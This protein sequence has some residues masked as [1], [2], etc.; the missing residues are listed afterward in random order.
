MESGTISQKDA[1]K[2][3]LGI[4]ENEFRKQIKWTDTKGPLSIG[5][6]RIIRSMMKREKLKEGYSIFKEDDFES[7]ML[8]DVKTKAKSV[9]SRESRFYILFHNPYKDDQT[10]VRGLMENPNFN[11]AAF[12]FASTMFGPLEGGKFPYAARLETMHKRA[13]QGEFASIST[14]GATLWR[15]YVLPYKMKQKLGPDERKINRSMYTLEH[16]T[17]RNPSDN[18]L[19]Y[20]TILKDRT[21]SFVVNWKDVI[22]FRK[23]Y[24]DVD[25]VKV[26]IHKNVKVHFGYGSGEGLEKGQRDDKSQITDLRGKNQRVTCIFSSTIDFKKYSEKNTIKAEPLQEILQ[27]AAYEG[28]IF[29]A[30]ASGC[31]KV[32]LTMVGGGSFRNNP[33]IILGSLLKVLKNRDVK[34]LGIDIYL[35]FRYDDRWKEY[36]VAEYDKNFLQYEIIDRLGQLIELTNHEKLGYDYVKYVKKYIEDAGGTSDELHRIQGIVELLDRY[37]IATEEEEE[38]EEERW[39]S[40]GKEEKEEEEEEEERWVSFGKEEEEEEEEEEESHTHSTSEEEEEEEEEKLWGEKHSGILKTVMKKIGKFFETKKDRIVFEK[41]FAEII[42][43]IYKRTVDRTNLERSYIYLVDNI[44]ADFLILF[45]EKKADR[46]YLSLEEF[47]EIMK[48]L[49]RK[50]KERKYSKDEITNDD[51]FPVW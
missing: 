43:L 40:F 22:N 10:D 33:K 32:V 19:P 14:I 39:F 17:S 49:A 51:C 36:P 45:K 34:K 50:Y 5:Y 3:V 8:G 47:K 44:I 21:T 7:E 1:V 30:A 42:Y 11:G 9:R 28:A 48:K 26:P 46:E 23:K 15:K 12:Q 18:R 38:E 20:K 24:D 16:F 31:K 25:L 4:S 29:G 35:N 27:T 41:T 37:D 6:D 2:G 13:V